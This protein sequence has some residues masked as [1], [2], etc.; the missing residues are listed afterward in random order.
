MHRGMGDWTIGCNVCC[1][2]VFYSIRFDVVRLGSIWFDWIGF[3]SLR[4]GS[5]ESDAIRVGPICIVVVGHLRLII[6]R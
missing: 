2:I 6:D 1:A 3:D 5:I 4:A